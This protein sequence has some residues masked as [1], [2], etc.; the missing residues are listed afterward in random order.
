M[1][2][3]LAEALLSKVM[4]WSDAEKAQE[5]AFL[6][7]FARYKYDE[8]QQFAPGR[9]FI[10]S[11][12]LWLRQF[13]T[14]DERRTAYK[15]IRHRLIF[16]SN[17]EMR[18]L[19]ELA[20]PTIIRPRLI[21]KA[22]LAAGLSP[23]RPKALL[24]STNYRSLVRRCLVLGLSDGARTDIFRRA[25]P[26]NFSNEQISHSYEISS[27][28]AIDMRKKLRKDLA[29]ILGSEPS[30]DQ[31]RFECV[32]LLDDF[33]ASGTSYLRPDKEENW[34]GKIWRV[35]QMLSDGGEL[36]DLVAGHDLQVMIVLYVAAQQAITHINEL[37][38]QIPFARGRIELEI[39][40]PLPLN[41]PLDDVK[42]ADILAIARAPE[43][44]DTDADD[45]HGAVGGSSKQLG[46]ADCRLPL[47][48]S[49]NTPNNSIF[50]LWGA[51]NYKF[52]G[53]FPRVD[54]HRRID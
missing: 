25:N 28:K 42:D 14:A 32:L 17:A 21:E 36:A 23:T 3:E 43:Y 49:H 51:E 35:A 6:Q 4:G 44:F 54:R 1:K 13:K 16:L 31:S 52:R 20:F 15:F 37:L 24:A 7:D 19:I 2:D 50:L 22:A 27:A 46:Y 9:R 40:H 39:V 33:T 5:R 8:Y 12:A 48:L 34:K 53:L 10:E 47:V 30:E 45:E 38:K 18:R 29:A 26:G 11:L 41:T